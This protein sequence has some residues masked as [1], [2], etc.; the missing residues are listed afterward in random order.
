MSDGKWQWIVPARSRTLDEISEDHD[1]SWS[2]C[3]AGSIDEPDNTLALRIRHPLG[4]VPRPVLLRQL[5]EEAKCL[6]VEVESREPGVSVV[7]LYIEATPPDRE[8]DFGLY[9]LGVEGDELPPLE[10]GLRRTSC[11]L[12]AGLVG[13]LSA[14]LRACLLWRAWSVFSELHAVRKFT[15]GVT[16]EVLVVQPLM[17]VPNLNPDDSV[18]VTRLLVK[19]ASEET[20]I[21]EFERTK[22]YVAPWAN[23]FMGHGRTL[24]T[25]L[26]MGDSVPGEA[27]LLGPFL[28]GE[29]VQTRNFVSYL[30]GLERPADRSKAIGQVFEL[31]KDWQRTPRI[32]PLRGWKDMFGP[33]DKPLLFNR[34]NLACSEDR[35]RLIEQ[36]ATLGVF[37]SRRHF[38]E[39]LWGDE[40]EPALLA[41]IS[42][43]RV[44]YSMCHGDLHPGNIL[45]DREQPWLIDFGN[46]GPAPLFFDY[47]KLEVYLR[48]QLIT[49]DQVTTTSS[50]AFQDLESALLDQMVTGASDYGSLESVAESLAVKEKEL[51]ILVN[52]IVEIR[53]LAIDRYRLYPD[54]RSYLAVL[55][56]VIF[57][58]LRYA[59]KKAEASNWVNFLWLTQ[60][61]WVVEDRLCLVLGQQ[62]FPR[63]SREVR[64]SHLM[65]RDWVAPAGAPARLQELARTQLGKSFLQPFLLGRG[66]FAG[67]KHHLDFYQHTI[68]RLALVERFLADPLEAFLKPAE[69]IRCALRHLSEQGLLLPPPVVPL[70]KIAAP[71]GFPE[72]AVQ[73]V[74]AALEQLQQPENALVLKWSA[75]F[76]TVGKTA[77]QRVCPAIRGGRSGLGH[78]GYSK[79]SRQ[80]VG[81]KFDEVLCEWCP[82][83]GAESELEDDEW[84]CLGEGHRFERT[85]DDLLS[86]VQFVI[87]QRES[88]A[89]GAS[90][91]YWADGVSRLKQAA[92]DGEVVCVLPEH[93][94]LFVGDMP[95]AVVLTYCSQLSALGV[96][97]EERLAY[98][99]ETMFYVLHFT[100][101]ACEEVGRV[102]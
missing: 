23:P 95:A 18:P 84:V 54:C 21:E 85:R 6:K 33:E 87:G 70:E 77:S 52:A 89:K 45:V 88:L 41:R 2:V 63:Y 86:R 73:A 75:L 93:T 81:S 65:P 100:L 55:Y 98:L 102:P 32:A 49:A 90:L 62:T 11:K 19:H 101:K 29:L 1:R 83:C 16:S 35:A 8:R 96:D 44:P 53:K 68:M 10:I 82:K 31:L 64:I 37:A 13:G 59:G 91:W 66:V 46:A 22:T 34:Y 74:S 97:S 51:T 25:V 61:A 48:L 39:H 20:L 15:T 30:K 14:Q 72:Q 50:L 17:L 26:P 79:V 28:G 94:H 3:F 99:A 24:L 38:F 40:G 76:E 57:K 92:V 71:S 58:T 47:V 42:Q 69:F 60:L 12:Q 36:Q 43:I 56:M 9:V 78:S 5:E 4:A 67:G 27:C 7:R 80:L